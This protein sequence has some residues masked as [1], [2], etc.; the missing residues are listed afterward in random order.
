MDD[1]PEELHKEIKLRTIDI[2]IGGQKLDQ[3]A[4]FKG[5]EF[6]AYKAR[7][8]VRKFE[9]EGL[10]TIKAIHKVFRLVVMDKL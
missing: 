6:L 7:S 3:L 9:Y 1:I 10:P 5:G 4:F 2:A 8:A